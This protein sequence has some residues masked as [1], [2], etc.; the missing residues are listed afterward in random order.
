MSDLSD[1]LLEIKRQKDEYILP[2][3]IKKDV[4]V[5]GVTG[6]LE[7]GSGSGVKLFDTVEHMQEDTTA[8]EGDVA[9]V[10]GD[11]LGG[12]SVNSKFVKLI[13]PETVILDAEVDTNY[14]IMLYGSSSTDFVMLSVNLYPEQFYIYSPMGEDYDIAYTSN[15]GINFTRTRFTAPDGMITGNELNFG[16]EMVVELESGAVFNDNF[17]K[18]MKCI[19]PEFGGIYKYA[20]NYLDEK[21]IYLLNI[22]DIDPIT[23]D[24]STGVI[25]NI[26][27]STR[28]NNVL[29]GN[30]LYEIYKKI[31]DDVPDVNAVSFFYNNVDEL[32]F[33]LYNEYGTSNTYKT[34]RYLVFSKDTGN[35]L[36]GLTCGNSGYNCNAK[37]YK[38]NLNT[39]DYTFDREY[40]PVISGS[41]I[42]SPIT[43]VKTCPV[44]I[45]FAQKGVIDWVYG[46]GLSYVP[47]STNGCMMTMNDVDIKYYSD[48]YILADTQLTA[49]ED[50]VF[51]LIY[52]GK[53]GVNTGKFPN[54]NLVSNSFADR[55]AEITYETTQV[56]ENMTPIDISSGYTVNKDIYFIPTNKN[57]QVLF[58]TSNKTTINNLFSGCKN[59]KKLPLIDTSNATDMQYAFANCT[60]LEEIANI[61]LSNMTKMMY[62]FLNCYNLKT[63]PDLNTPNLATIYDTFAGCKSLERAPMLNVSGCRSMYGMFRGCS[64]LVYVPS[65]VTSSLVDMQNIF[66]GCTSLVTI[67]QFDLSNLT[68]LSNEFYNC[69]NLSDESLN[70]ILGM[71]AGAVSLS[72]STIV[73]NLKRAGL[74]QE[75]ATK[76]TT[77]SN[78]S[79]CQNKGWVT[80]Y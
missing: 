67:P 41:N 31:R 45:Q 56:Y 66:S 7:A 11:I 3:N 79:A 26:S 24:S 42:Y 5:Y 21:K 75:Q 28:T 52:Y 10:Y 4:T 50:D 17:G 80:G 15:D 60:S 46:I 49:G 8:K 33:V 18:F 35:T 16:I 72:T 73:R 13:F 25:T 6:T 1:K 39:L 51:N 2:E 12:I 58:D 54:Y 22:S 74:S 30:V 23:F 70:I 44:S 27:T 65:Y 53:D 36:L 57:G 48:E 55:Y 77:L 32:C 38:V 14:E 61:D 63:I 71:F 43:D 19:N 69:P 59:L 40:A 20:V 9:L 64:S 68:Y 34:P 78:W 62:A 47:T 29:D 76:C 37:V